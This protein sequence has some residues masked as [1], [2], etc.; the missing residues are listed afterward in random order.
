MFRNGPLGGMFEVVDN[1]VSCQNEVSC[2]NEVYLPLLSIFY[3]T[4][5]LL[6]DLKYGKLLTFSYQHTNQMNVKIN[7]MI[8][9]RLHFW[10]RHLVTIF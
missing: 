10:Q 6:F 3:V 2:E 1:D 5:C 7:V 8:V 9:D 4:K